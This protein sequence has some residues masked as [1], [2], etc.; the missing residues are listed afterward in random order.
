MPIKCPVAP[1]EFAFLADWY[2]RERGVR[3]P[4]RDLVYST[5]LDSAFTKPTCSE[6][7]S[8]VCS[9][10]RRS[11]SSR[12]STRGRSTG[13]TASSSPTTDASSTS[14]CSSTIPLHGGASY[15]E[16]SDGLGD[17]LGFVPTDKATLQTTVKPNVF[18]LGDATDVP[19]SKAGSVDALRG[20]GTRRERRSLPR[21]RGARGGYD[22][23]A[24]CFIEN[25]FPQGSADR[26]QLRHRATARPLPLT[27]SAC[28]SCASRASTTWASSRSSGSTGTPCFR[29]ATIPAIGPRMP[30]RGKQQIPVPAERRT[31]DD[32]DTDR[33]LAGRRRRR[34]LHDG[35]GAVERGR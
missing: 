30:T 5:P 3:S 20:G 9:T 8:S 32:H 34:G 25:G 16:R 17:A 24:N 14:T 11:S 31:R 23:H 21:R 27:A 28:R 6:Q 22:G 12:S 2:L 1:L 29:A 35:P 7:L 10:R 4:Q 19:T 15:V 33:G 18:A 13:S 26:L